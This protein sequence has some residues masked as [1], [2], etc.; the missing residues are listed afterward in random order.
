MKRILPLLAS[1]AVLSLLLLTVSCKDKTPAG[2][3]GVANSPAMEKLIGEAPYVCALP[4]DPNVLISFH[5]LQLFTKS[6]FGTDEEFEYY[7]NLFLDSVDDPM[8]RIGISGMLSN[9]AV[10]G[11]D[12]KHPCLAALSDVK[13]ISSS[14][15]DPQPQADLTVSIPL[16]NNAFILKSVG[17]EMEK[18]EDGNYYMIDEKM[19]VVVAPRLIV[20]YIPVNKYTSAEENLRYLLKALAKKSFHAG[21]FLAETVLLG[22][23]DMAVYTDD[24]VSEISMMSFKEEIGQDPVTILGGNPF[25]GIEALCTLDF[26]TGK[27]VG[28]ARYVGEN[29]LWNRYCSWIGTP[30]RELLNALPGDSQLAGQLAFQHLSDALD[31]AQ[32][33]LERIDGAEGFNLPEILAGVGLSPS[34]LDDIATVAFGF[35]GGKGFYGDGYN[36]EGIVA[37]QTG[38]RL[39]ATVEDLLKKAGMP[40]DAYGFRLRR[41]IHL[42]VVG[43]GLLLTVSS[44]QEIPESRSGF[45]SGNRL[46]SL[47]KGNSMAVDLSDNTFFLWNVPVELRIFD[48]ARFLMTDPARVEILME[49]KQANAAK[50]LLLALLPYLTP[51]G[52]VPDV[53]DYDEFYYDF[54]DFAEYEPVDSLGYLY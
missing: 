29:P 5:L 38:A 46:T 27:V 15:G 4:D 24:S 36:A 32:K 51:Q 35:Y 25:K 43:E 50:S 21:G 1:A 39:A 26:Q 22:E 19:A 6:G 34:D 14:W 11:F 7:R 37:I 54:D 17:D 12:T 10:A 44:G 13:V 2:R 8:E 30:D 28:D 31:Y 48:Y 41:G 45:V 18:K 20:A 16:V 49:D 23:S 33:C 40:G 53:D 52:P 9:P 42:N 3:A 47:L